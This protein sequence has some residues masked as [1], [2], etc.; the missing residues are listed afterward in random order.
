MLQPEEDRENDDPFSTPPP[1][2]PEPPVPRPE[3]RPDPS[4]SSCESDCEPGLDHV[5]AA[6]AAARGEKSGGE[7]HRLPHAPGPA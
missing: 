4:M 6:T 2:N 1:L 5:A 7:P 3:S